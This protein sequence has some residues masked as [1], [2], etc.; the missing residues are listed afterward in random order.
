MQ[1]SAWRTPSGFSTLLAAAESA[2]RVT[3]ADQLKS[4]DCSTLAFTITRKHLE[5]RVVSIALIEVTVG[6]LAREAPDL[7]ATPD[8][9]P[10]RVTDNVRRECG[11]SRLIAQDLLELRTICGLSCMPNRIAAGQG[12]EDC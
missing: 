7:L 1:L 8:L 6:Q 10:G 4:P 11:E 2:G 5:H 12:L 3:R 9:I